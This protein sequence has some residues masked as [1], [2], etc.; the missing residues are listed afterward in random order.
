MNIQKKTSILFALMSLVLFAHLNAFAQ[1]KTQ[2][3]STEEFRSAYPKV[4]ATLSAV[5]E[6]IRSKFCECM[7]NKYTD[8]G[9]TDKTTLETLKK[10]YKNTLPP[11]DKITDAEKLLFNFDANSAEACLEEVSH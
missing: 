1:K 2:K 8:R 10:V 4:C 7:T 11:N 9:Y 6:S 5:P 3:M